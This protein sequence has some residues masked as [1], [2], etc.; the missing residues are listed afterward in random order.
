LAR[1]IGNLAEDHMA[2]S[3]TSI[4]IKPTVAFNLGDTFV[5]GS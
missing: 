4:F 1:Q 5:L 2:N 3:T